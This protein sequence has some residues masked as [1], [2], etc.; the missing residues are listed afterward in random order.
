MMQRQLAHAC[1]D[2]TLATCPDVA[3]LRWPSGIYVLPVR[4]GGASG[5]QIAYCPWCGNRL[6]RR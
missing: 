6:S 5:Y 3:V 4:D 1:P 2:N